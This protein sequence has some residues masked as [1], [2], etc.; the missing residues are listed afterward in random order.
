MNYTQNY[1][2]NQWEA[3]DRVLRT[4]FNND[5]AKIDAAL[6]A[7]ADSV[8]ALANRSRFT[9]LKEVNV[10]ADTNRVEIDLR[11]ID[12]TQWDKVHLDYLATNGSQMWLF[13]NEVSTGNRLYSI[14]GSAG[15]YRPWL[16]FYVGF[17]ADR[18]LS[19]NGVHS[20][21]SNYIPYSQL[22]KFIISENTMRPGAHF[23]VWGE[24]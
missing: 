16:T 2:L 14:S 20:D 17:R 19:T 21:F 4:D 1:Q 7:N 11:G 6:K 12:W 23:I 22:Q 24:K 3:T 18:V 15:L 13:I 8:T 5:N 10:T 9:K